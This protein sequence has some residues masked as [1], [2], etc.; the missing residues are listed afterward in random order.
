MRRLHTNCASRA[1]ILTGYACFDVVVE[2]VDSERACIDVKHFAV[3]QAPRDAVADVDV[4][5]GF[6]K[7]T[8]IVQAV[9]RA[10]P[11]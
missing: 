8:V 4:G 9:E 7:S 2:H 10:R 6:E 1:R 3:V 11:A 5:V